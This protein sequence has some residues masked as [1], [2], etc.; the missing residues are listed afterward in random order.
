[1]GP[2]QVGGYLI[3][4]ASKGPYEPLIGPLVENE[5][6]RSLRILSRRPSA[7]EGFVASL[8]IECIVMDIISQ[9]QEQANAMVLLTLNTFRT[10]QRDASPVRLSPNYP[11]PTA[12]ASEET[13]DIMEHPKTMSAALV[14]AVKK[15]EREDN[16]LW[17]LYIL[18][19]LM[20]DSSLPKKTCGLP[21]AH[22]LAEY[23]QVD[24]LIPLDTVDK[25]LEE[26][27]YGGE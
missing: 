11:E 21:C 17:S 20:D 1:M 14:E 3:L 5:D 22:E 9:L 15:S 13:I 26:V 24:M 8:I 16:Y 4:K 6:F 7:D 2:V 25:F 19:S 10:L 23:T 12:N 27:R 18:R